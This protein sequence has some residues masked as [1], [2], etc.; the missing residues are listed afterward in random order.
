MTDSPRLQSTNL[1]RTAG[2]RV[3]RQRVAVLDVVEAEP[4]TSAASVL[5]TVS[6][7]LPGVSHQAVYDCL[8]HLTD[9]GLLRRIIVDG[10]PALYETRAHDNHHHCVCRACG[11]VVDVEGAIG[12]APR[13]D[14][15]DVAGFV[16]E[17]TEVIYRG[18][19][20]PCASAQPALPT[21]PRSSIR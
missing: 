10:G 3:T 18:L 4:H 1:I 11:L 16:I 17:E 15:A 5:A 6:A 2:M 8:T 14:I 12:V 20:M 13:L 7:V 19:C 9:A 21:S